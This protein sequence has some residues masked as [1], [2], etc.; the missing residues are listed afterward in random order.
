MS[1]RTDAENLED[2]LIK[3]RRQ[4]HENPELGFKEYETTKLICA[5]LDKLGIPYEKEV[6]L[7]GIVATLEGGKGTGKT[8]LIRA[9]MDALPLI[10]ETNLPFKSKNEGVFHACG[11]DSHVSCLLGTAKILKD[12]VSEFK[13]TVKF[14]FQPAEEQSREPRA[15]DG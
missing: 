3:T 7:T 1:I 8:L 14:V 11:H 2:F 12:R 4:I 10:E 9:D 6:A 13:G 15:G 5:E